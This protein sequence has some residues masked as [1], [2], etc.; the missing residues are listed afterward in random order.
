MDFSIIPV[1]EIDIPFVDLQAQQPDIE[2]FSASALIFLVDHHEPHTAYV[3][4]CQRALLGKD[5]KGNDKENS[6]AF[7]WE[8]P[9]GSQEIFD[10]TILNTAKRETEEEVNL[11]GSRVASQVY[12]DSWMHKGVPMARYTFPLEVD[13]QLKVQRTWCDRK[14][15]PVGRNEGPIR[16]REDEHLDY[17]WATEA[18]IRDSP[19]YD[20]K[21]PQHQRGLV[22]LESKKDMILDA[23]MRL[24]NSQLDMTYALSMD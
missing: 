4:L 13:E 2:R 9:G 15:Q 10:K 20:G 19:S 6:W 17:C 7:S 24:K 5:E 18:Q 21:D 11:H 23:F 8:P 3:L 22:M 1:E 16:L 14:Q 12:R